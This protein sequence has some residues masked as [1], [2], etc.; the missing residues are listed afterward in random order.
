MNHLHSL[1][2]AAILVNDF[3]EKPLTKTKELIVS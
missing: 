2:F 3:A 1:R